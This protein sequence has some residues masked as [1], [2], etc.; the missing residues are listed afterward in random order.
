M[1]RLSI[2]LA[3]LLCGCA[4]TGIEQETMA[5][6]VV[7]GSLAPSPD[8]AVATN[9]KLRE[10]QQRAIDKTRK[11]LQAFLGESSSNCSSPR[12]KEAA[13]RATDVA[14]AMASAMRPEY[15]ALLAA[16]SVVLDVADGAKSKGCQAQAKRLYDFVLKNFSGLGYAALR[17]RAAT[18][19]RGVRA[20][21]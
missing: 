19:A 1:R 2:I 11:P 7:T 15:E 3:L 17:D 10:E 4:G 21:G 12:L 6:A 13:T 8:A 20:E 9:V 14:T 18:G 16:G 5:D